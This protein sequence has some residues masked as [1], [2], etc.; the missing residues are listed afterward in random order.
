MLGKNVEK[1]GQRIANRLGERRDNILAR[2]KF[3]L[4]KQRQYIDF[5]QRLLGIYRDTTFVEIQK[6]A[7]SVVTDL[8][9]ELKDMDFRTEDGRFQAIATQA[10][11]RSMEW[12]AKGRPR[13]EQE[14]TERKLRR[15]ILMQ[16][17]EE[18][19]RKVSRKSG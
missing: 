1:R 2:N 5:F 13:V 11:I 6:M 8:M 10:E 19:E 9:Q 3:E 7:Q 17:I 4:N 12:F 14:L 16:E 18:M 15:D